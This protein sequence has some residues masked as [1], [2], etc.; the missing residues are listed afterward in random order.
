MD[1]FYSPSMKEKMPVLEKQKAELIQILETAEEPPVLLHPNMALEYHKRIDGLFTALQD[2][3]TQME[4]SEDIR[5]LIVTLSS[6]LAR[7]T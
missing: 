4:A 6:P 7:A 3:Q 1:G 2:K 5:A